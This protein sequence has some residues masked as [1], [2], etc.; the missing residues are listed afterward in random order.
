M[1][2]LG[3]FFISGII[4]LSNQIH[5]FLLFKIT[6]YIHLECLRAST[7]QM[8]A[9]KSIFKLNFECLLWLNHSKF[10]YSL[11]EKICLKLF[12]ELVC[13]YIYIYIY[14]YI[15]RDTEIYREI[16]RY[17]EIYIQRE[18]ERERENVETSKTIIIR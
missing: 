17:T 13:I 14:I 4:F 5:S 16:H 18:R 9:K 3:A 6:T 10:P 11:L 1:R 2:K 15:Q 8:F 12:K 7:L